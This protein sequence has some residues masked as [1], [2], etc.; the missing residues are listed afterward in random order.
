MRWLVLHAT[1]R[2]AVV[3]VVGIQARDCAAVVQIHVVRVALIVLGGGPEVRGAARDGEFPVAG[4]EA[5][6]ER[7]EPENVFTIAITGP[8]RG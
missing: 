4:P 1:N 6:R 5:G 3:L 7:R 2:V 8:T